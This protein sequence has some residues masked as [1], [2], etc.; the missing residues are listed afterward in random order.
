MELVNIYMYLGLTLQVTG[1]A[2]IK[3]IEERCTTGTKA[4]FD[5]KKLEKISLRMALRL[6][7]I[8]V[9]PRAYYAITEI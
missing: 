7:H 5:I 6:F 2:F 9:A 8:K 4:I 3:H 1:K